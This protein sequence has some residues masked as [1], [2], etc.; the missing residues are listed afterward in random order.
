MIISQIKE[1]QIYLY[2]FKLV[3]RFSNFKHIIT[4]THNKVALI[5]LNRPKSL[6]ALCDEMI[7][8]LN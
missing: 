7:N 8:E 5:K 6:N 1:Q 4:E 2:M 3:F